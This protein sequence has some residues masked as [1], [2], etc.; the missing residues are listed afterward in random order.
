MRPIIDTTMNM[1]PSVGQ[2]PGAAARADDGGLHAHGGRLF[3]KYLLFILSLVSLALLLS[4]AITIYFS[5]QEH[6]SALSEMQ[7]EKAVAAAA[8]IEQ[9]LAYVT[10][11]LSHATMPQIDAADGDT[12]RIEFLKILR[13]APEI[14][15]IALL[16]RTGREQLLVSRL[17]MDAIGSGRDRSLEPAFLNARRGERWL[18][19]VYFRQETEPYL[20]ASIRS[21]GDNGGVTVIDVNLK[22]IWDVISRIKVGD[23]GKAY[24]VDS[25]GM[26]IADP[27]IGMVL[28]KTRLADL[29]HVQAARRVAAGDSPAMLSRNLDG[30]PILVS[31]APIAELDWKVFVEQPVDE[32][33]AK[34][35][36]SI[37]RTVLLLLG[38]FGISAVGAGLLARSMVRPIHTLGQGAS[39]IAA[40]D[41]AQRIE[42]QTGDELQGLAEQFNQMSVRL[43][44][45]YSDLESRVAMRTIELQASLERQ[46]A[47]S[48]IL[49]SIAASPTDVAPVLETIAGAATRLCGASTASIYL[50]RGSRL[51]HVVTRGAGIASGDPPEAIAIDQGSIS[52]R[53]VIE[54]RIIQ[55][56]DVLERADEYPLAGDLAQRLGHRT[57]AATPLLREGEPFGVILLRR[58]EARRFDQN[59]TAL[60]KIF[61]DQA[62]IAIGNAR[63]FCEIQEKSHQLEI[64]N[65]HKSEFLANMSHELRTP[66]NAIIGFSEVM[67]ERMFGDVNPKQDE[68]LRDIHASGRHLL[69]LINDILDLSKIEA[70]R[71]ELDLTVF[72]LRAAVADALAL[73]R[74]RARRRDIALMQSIDPT[75]GELRADERK[76]KQIL[77]NLMTNAVKFTPD[78]GSI[79][80]RARLVD[81][82]VEFAVTDNGV[83]IRAEDLQAIFE[84]FRQVGS[85][86]TTKEEGTGLGLAL[87]RRFV[88]LHGGSLDVVSAPGHGSTFSFTLPSRS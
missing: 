41:L 13:Q 70:G 42:V 21:G 77:L 14:T 22:F 59:D 76:F 74:E 15:E 6:R 69:S 61:G 30:V 44:E 80:L 4:G 5:Y 27:D 35:N 78:G 48:E 46:T 82:G 25:S 50:V 20:T 12:R 8:R 64:A 88:E 49:R 16:D 55:V 2:P 68:Y 62:A 66:L 53:A 9:Y 52:G 7:K 32:V 86:Y 85:G 31:V 75:L 81:A 34:L 26:L 40:G 45:S 79:E 72:D 54:R 29:P 63:L 51:E 24:I 39:R 84:A 57:V 60:L 65:Q 1:Q 3:R 67:I 83:G 71:M 23:R 19:P 10:R 17:G 33:Y 43:R 73:V 47:I 18:G 28:R 11:Q 38:G 36:A 37:V 56:D 58:E 87:T